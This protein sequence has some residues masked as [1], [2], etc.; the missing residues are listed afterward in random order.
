MVSRNR[1]L[2]VESIDT[3]TMR[4]AMDRTADCCLAWLN[5]EDDFLPTGGYEVAHDTGRWWDAMLRYEAA[6]GR[7]IPQQAEK[8]MMQNLRLL[9]NN[10]VALLDREKGVS[11]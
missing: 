8:R 2:G 11:S 5:P 6:T 4:K 9:T 10:P 1:T 7:A 3:G